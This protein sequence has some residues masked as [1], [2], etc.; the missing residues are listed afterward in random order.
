[1]P[2]CDQG[3]PQLADQQGEAAIDRNDT[4]GNGR[5]EPP[6]GGRAFDRI[7]GERGLPYTAIARGIDV[8]GRND[9]IGVRST[10]DATGFNA[11]HDG[12]R[13]EVAV[14]NIEAWKKTVISLKKEQAMNVGR[15]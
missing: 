5:G 1:M 8:A 2:R 6:N 12:D 4:I 11:V 9:R 7:A 15:S 10:S 13:V 14:E 3:N